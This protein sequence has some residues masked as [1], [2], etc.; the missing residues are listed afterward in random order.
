MQ[1]SGMFRRPRVRDRALGS[2]VRFA[3][4][5][6]RNTAP[7]AI[8]LHDAIG[9]AVCPTGRDIVP[10]VNRLARAPRDFGDGICWVM[11]TFD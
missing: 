10:Q 2:R 9:Y 11:D 8:D 3:D 5:L 6:A 1:G 7:V 4:L